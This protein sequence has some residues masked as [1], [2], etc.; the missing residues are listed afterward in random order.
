MFF[1]LLMF[2]SQFNKEANTQTINVRGNSTQPTIYPDNK[3]EYI[4]FDGELKCGHIYIYEKNDENKTLISHRFAYESNDGEIY[5]KGDSNT[6]MDN[7]IQ[8]NQ[9]K[10][11]IVGVNIK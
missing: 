9:I 1:S 5:F 4:D 7:P 3:L 10:F 11:E 8:I 2:G 6:K